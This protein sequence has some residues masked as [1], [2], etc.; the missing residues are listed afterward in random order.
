MIGRFLSDVVGR[1]RT[2]KGIRRLRARERAE[3]EM[4]NRRIDDGSIWRSGKGGS[5]QG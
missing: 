4:R 1:I 5:H 2:T 3:V